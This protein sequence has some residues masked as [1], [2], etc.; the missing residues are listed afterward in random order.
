VEALSPKNNFPSQEAPNSQAPAEQITATKEITGKVLENLQVSNLEK[1][2]PLVVEYL[3]N[4][5]DSF[6][7]GQIVH[8]LC[9]WRKITSDAEV[10]QTVCGE[11]IDR[12]FFFALASKSTKGK[13]VFHP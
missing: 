11:E 2:L 12:V 5:A 6:Q 3:N 1:D 4:R 9:E 7:A 13:Q 8:K 10:L